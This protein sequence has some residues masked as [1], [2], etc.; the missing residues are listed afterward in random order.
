[1]EHNEEEVK[2]YK[3]DVERITSHVRENFD[4]ILKEVEFEDVK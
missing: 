2:L 4:E 3:E 1:M